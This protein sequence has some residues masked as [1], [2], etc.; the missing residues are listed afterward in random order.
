MGLASWTATC[1]LCLACLCLSLAAAGDESKCDHEKTCKSSKDLED[2]VGL[3]QEVSFLRRRHEAP[4]SVQEQAKKV[5]A[6]WKAASTIDCSQYPV[7]CAA[8]FNCDSAPPTLAQYARWVSTSLV[9][10]EGH[11]DMKLWCD[12][13]N[14]K[15]AN[16]LVQ[17]CLKD[18]NLKKSAQ[19]LQARQAS[20]QHREREATYCFAEGH[21]SDDSM[22]EDTTA[23]EAEAHC[24]SKYGPLT[25]RSVNGLSRESTNRT[26]TAFYGKL[27]CA[28]GSFHCDAMYCKETY[29]KDAKYIKQH[30]LSTGIS[31]QFF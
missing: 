18:G 28:M 29:C 14:R 10:E 30:L 19:L 27:A 11:P 7:L 23:Q 25:W 26:D 13:S 21:C 2:D 5:A 31:S 4:A 1:T 22:S 9:T 15:M 24:D 20:E 12:V 8:P 17:H 6:R 16:S 3:L